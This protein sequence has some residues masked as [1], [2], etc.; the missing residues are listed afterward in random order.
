MLKLRHIPSAVLLT[1]ALACAALPQQ[2]KTLLNDVVEPFAIRPGSSFAASGAAADVNSRR[3]SKIA[4]D[5]LEAERIIRENSVDGKRVGAS[6]LTKKALEGALRTLD[7]HSSYFDQ[8][9]WRELLDEE[10]SGYTGIGATIGAYEQNGVTDTYV[11][12]TFPGSP[13]ARAGLRFGDRVVSIDGTN[14]SGKEDE[15]VRDHIRGAVGTAIRMVV[16]RAATRRYE[17]VE[18]RRGRVPQPSIPDAY[19]LRPGVGY[20]ELS[21][22]FNYTTGEEFDTAMRELKRQGMRALILDLRENPGGIVDQAVHVAER[23]LPAGTL[24][25]TQRGRARI[26]NRVWQSVNTSPET[27]PLVVLVNENTA[28]ASEIV[29]GALQDNDRALLVGGKTFGKGLVQSVIDLPGQTG[30]TLTTARYLTPSGRSIQRDYSKLDLTD[31]YN[32]KSVV[33]DIDRPYFEARTITNRR[34][35]GG[36]GIQ[37]D[38][39]LPGDKLTQTQSRL[40]DPIFFFAR[41]VQSAKGAIFQPAVFGLSTVKVDDKL[42]ENFD[43]FALKDLPTISA[44]DLDENKDFIRTRLK[45]E[46]AMAAAGSNAADQ[47][48]IQDDPQI[49]K[50]MTLFPQ[51]AE[52]ARLAQSAKKK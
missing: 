10:Q 43:S 50:A 16:E 39:P 20:I 24:I 6:D 38:V 12:A 23:F 35:Y 22:G 15:T 26:D 21:E 9:E 34:V 44:K 31:Y 7:P 3:P 46:F 14:M 18:I 37:P 11:L 2:P 29:A 49:A 8:A 41:E 42:I 30:L 33:S 32:H 4:A 45:Y 1:G 19:I 40:L 28:S 47:V 48:L 17:S 27:M 25:L 5:I 51:A 36:D 52:L 13:A